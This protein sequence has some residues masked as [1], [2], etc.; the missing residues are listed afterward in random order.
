MIILKRHAE[1]YYIISTCCVVMRSALLADKIQVDNRGIF[2][3]EGT[4]V[5]YC[6]FCPTR[7]EVEVNKV[8]SKELS[9][10]TNCGCG[11]YIIVTN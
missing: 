1:Y 10:L 5:S 2:H 7:I 6:P 3:I 8:S 9:I 4:K 11:E